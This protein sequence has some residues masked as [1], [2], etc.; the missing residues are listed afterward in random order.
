LFKIKHI[1][2]GIVGREMMRQEKEEEE[3]VLYRANADWYWEVKSSS[4]FRVTW[5][6]FCVSRK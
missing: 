6:E 1:I 2:N 5:E 3:V 4:D